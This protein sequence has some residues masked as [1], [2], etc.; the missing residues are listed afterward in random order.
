MHFRVCVVPQ[1][2]RLPKSFL[3]WRGNSAKINFCLH[4]RVRVV[5]QT[6]RKPFNDRNYSNHSA[7]LGRPVAY[8]SSRA[9]T[10][11][12][13]YAYLPSRQEGWSQGRVGGGVVGST[14]RLNHLSPEGWWSFLSDGIV[15]T[16]ACMVKALIYLGN[17][18]IWWTSEQSCNIMKNDEQ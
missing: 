15:K 5:P 18:E 2:S 3:I 1:T 8:S 9:R 6:S 7:R 16:G 4:F 13:T 10:R 14:G 12:K 11:P 17:N